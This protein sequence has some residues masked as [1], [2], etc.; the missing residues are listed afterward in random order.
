MSDNGF[1]YARGPYETDERIAASAWSKGDLLGI[2]STS[3]LSRVD[4]QTNE[5]MKFGIALADSTDSI[6]GVCV[7]MIP[8]PT[9]EFWLPATSDLTTGASSGVTFDVASGRY[10]ADASSTTQIVKIVKGTDELDQSI[11]SHVLVRF[12]DSATFALD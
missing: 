11:R 4:P 12:A 10:A 3:S 8:D 5:V 9:T 7:V 6:R 1:V 2:T